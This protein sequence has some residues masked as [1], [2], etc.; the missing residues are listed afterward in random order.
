MATQEK[1]KASVEEISATF[2]VPSPPFSSARG[3]VGRNLEVNSSFPLPTHNRIASEDWLKVSQAQALLQL[4]SKNAGV[5]LEEGQGK[6]RPLGAMSTGV[7][8][9][10]RGI[11]ESQVVPWTRA[12]CYVCRASEAQ[13]PGAQDLLLDSYFKN[14]QSFV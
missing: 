5:S 3:R 1:A 4:G 14:A 12:C 6:S 2:K 9:S 8:S 11:H 10:V 7:L 13:A